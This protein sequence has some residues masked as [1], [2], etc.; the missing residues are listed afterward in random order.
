MRR[1]NFQE[2]RDM[3]I[4]MLAEGDYDWD[5]AATDGRTDGRTDTNER[6]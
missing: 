2:V 4:M 1:D 3:K 6:Q 5:W